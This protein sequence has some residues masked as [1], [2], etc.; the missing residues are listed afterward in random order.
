MAGKTGAESERSFGNAW[1]WSS[2]IS[3]VGRFDLSPNVGSGVARTMRRKS[4]SGDCRGFDERG[5]REAVSS[6]GSVVEPW[7]L[8]ATACELNRWAFVAIPAGV[9]ST[10]VGDCLPDFSSRLSSLLSIGK[11]S[12]TSRERTGG[13]FSTGS[14]PLFRAVESL[15]RALRLRYSAGFFAARA[16][17]SAAELDL[18]YRSTAWNVERRSGLEQD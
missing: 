15:W 7:P 10:A 14:S 1:E 4:R 3:D 17:F 16:R 11:H 13:G 18:R 8:E 2:G 9:P 12:A 6:Q 5:A